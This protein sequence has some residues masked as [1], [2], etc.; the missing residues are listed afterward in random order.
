MTTRAQEL[1]AVADSVT[2]LLGDEA[3]EELALLG[4]FDPDRVTGV[5]PVALEHISDPLRPRDG[6]RQWMLKEGPRTDGLARWLRAERGKRRTRP[7]AHYD[8]PVQRA[9]DH[10]LDGDGAAGVVDD[11]TDTELLAALDVLRWITTA[12]SKVDVEF[13]LP[14]DLDRDRIEAHLALNE[15]LAP[16]RR[17]MAGG[18]LGRDVE[19]AKL[20]AFSTAT[21]SW[22][23]DVA[24][25]EGPLRTLVV[26][27]IG[28]VGKSTL[29]AAHVDELRRSPDHVAWAYLD[30]D[31]PT[32]RSYR[33]E[34]IVD[35]VL[36]QV[37]SQFHRHRRRVERSR[38]AYKASM[39]GSGLETLG[40]EDWFTTVN[41]IADVVSREADGRLVVVLDTFEEFQRHEAA[42]RGTEGLRSTTG[43]SRSDELRTMFSSLASML[44]GFRLILSGRAPA[45][46]A[47]TDAERIRVTEFEA[48]EAV[49]VL[50]AFHADVSSTSAG[51]DGPG[52]DTALARAVV[53]A[54]GG[55]PLTLR[56]AARVIARE[57]AA[58]VGDAAHRARA[59][60]LVRD[61]FVRGFLY[62]RILDHLQRPGEP[63]GD[64]L[65]LVAKASLPLRRLDLGLLEDVVLPTLVDL[66]ELEEASPGMAHELLALLRAESALVLPSE[67]L[68]L[69][70]DVRG[71]A[72]A[73]LRLDDSRLVQAV[74]EAAASHHAEGGPSPDRAEHLYHRLAAGHEVGEEELRHAREVVLDDGFSAGLPPATLERLRAVEDPGR[75]TSDT[76]LRAWEAA[77]AAE[78]RNLMDA[79]E[80]GRAAELL[81]ER[82]DRTAA[83]PLHAVEA[84][85]RQAQGLG[86]QALAAAGRAVEASRHTAL[87]AHYAAAVLQLAL[88]HERLG[89]PGGGM[90]ALA[91]AES[92]GLVAGDSAARLELQLN[93]WTMA[94]RAGLPLDT[95]MEELD[96]RE[97][98]IRLGDGALDY[99]TSLWRLLAATLGGVESRY[100]REAVSRVGIGPDPPADLLH[101][102]ASA[103]ADW[104]TTG[105]LLEDGAAVKD[106]PDS[107]VAELVYQQLVGG[108]TAA[109]QILS[110]ALWTQE[111]PAAVTEALRPLFVWWGID[112]DRDAGDGATAGSGV[113]FLD[114]HLDFE[115]DEHRQLAEVLLGAYPHQE[116]LRNLGRRIGVR[117]D[118][119][120]W[121]LPVE[122]LARPFLRRAS[123]GPGLG[124]VAEHLLTDDEAFS[125]HLVVRD[126]VG[127]DWLREHDL[128]EPTQA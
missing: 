9:L 78:C 61:E 94:E 2:R 57:G 38:I 37:G 117:T 120:D 77:T 89:D 110:G 54:V 39:R 48:D 56:L 102:L 41:T 86:D 125:Y 10:A 5:D 96:A 14:S 123:T 29:V 43:S 88:L 104:D 81:D 27:G 107:N 11:W 13:P 83:S 90:S 114:Q 58:A 32:L 6:G 46:L 108:G 103:L 51:G 62:H 53:E 67:P 100:L 79:N 40:H 47:D 16:I 111:P 66:D 36:R 82:A 65:P 34:V 35:D 22:G 113:H 19:L 60:S 70:P 44:P 26:H 98:L 24:T 95:W 106:V 74:H 68:R 30:L 45:D 97:Q 71:P 50:R 52:L 112:R 3:V 122:Q 8:T 49:E 23:Q 92:T 25:V 69:R 63:F 7:P 64:M 91:E 109:Q 119:L 93:R 28:G 127:R 1:A 33:A 42:G 128:D 101:D 84:R 72:L 126:M 73:A 116:D 59:V 85:I 124:A 115:H 17:L 12:R 99:Y 105:R 76:E 18:C 87:P 118:D 15:T 80:V 55:S 121:H 75:D 4:T 20:R 21:G 31:R